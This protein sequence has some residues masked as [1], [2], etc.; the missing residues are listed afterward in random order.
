MSATPIAV[1]PGSR[2][3]STAT[4]IGMSSTPD[5]Y[6]I[7]PPSI[8]AIMWILILYAVFVVPVNFFTLRRLKRLEL[9]WIT[10]PIIS[11]LFSFILLNSTIDLYK[12]NATTRTVSIAILGDDGADSLIF[13]KS[14][15]F[16]PR[17]K[18][19]DLELENVESVYSHESYRYSASSGVNVV[20]TGR[21]IEAP[22][23]QTGNLAF[24]ELS[25]VQSSKELNGLKITLIRS[26]GAP[27]LHIVNQ[28][29]ANLS[30]IKIFG[31]G[32]QKD[33]VEPVKSGA[34]IQIPVTNIIRSK[35][36]SKEDN[37]ATGW[38]TLSSTSPNKIIVLGAIDSMKVGP[39]YGAGHP[40]SN[41]MILS[42]PQWSD[43]R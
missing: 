43:E 13:A 11:V 3:S 4:P 40:A 7:K 19:Y 39:K 28:S 6:Q 20:D 38:Q 17:A 5:P 23:V 8:A 21:N 14:E 10:T 15:M 34:S 33:V 18:S 12:A 32:I 26:N 42:V 16:F 30:S 35:P 25:Y 27:L 37:S 1:A 29:H 41:Y 31:P 2:I 9:A 36:N 24:K 22:N